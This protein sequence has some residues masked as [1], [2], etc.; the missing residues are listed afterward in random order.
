MSRPVFAICVGLA[1]MTTGVFAGQKST[2]DIAASM[3]SYRS[4]E[5]A[6]SG[7]HIISQKAY[8]LCVPASPPAGPH[9]SGL[10]EVRVNPTGY[11]AFLNS[12]GSVPVGTIVV[13]EKRRSEKDPI[14]LLTV[15]QKVGERGS[16]DDWRFYAFSGD[17]KKE[18]A[19]D[20]A[21][22]RGCHKAANADHLFRTYL[23]RRRG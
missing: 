4:W 16:L 10:I 7:P 9:T 5:K 12:T 15:M 1:A 8:A 21:K 23:L 20:A 14:D 6:T 18:L 17:G 22:C 19:T 2:S 11:R 3:K 13:K